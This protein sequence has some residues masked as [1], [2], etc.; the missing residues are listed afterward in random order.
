MNK[1]VRDALSNLESAVDHAQDIAA[2]AAEM[3]IYGALWTD[4]TNAA[5]RCAS[6]LE[7][8]KVAPGAANTESE[9]Q[10]S[11]EPSVDEKVAD[12]KSG[13]GTYIF[14]RHLGNDKGH[15]ESCG[16]PRDLAVCCAAVISGLVHALPNRYIIA[17]ILSGCDHA[18][19]TMEDLIVTYM[20]V[21]GHV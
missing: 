2:D 9:K 12:V 18:G 14:A 15:F 16:D 20:G 19:I 21:H 13:N 11:S 6:D 10:N 7:H 8:K 3:N 17:G 4:M 1:E 5:A